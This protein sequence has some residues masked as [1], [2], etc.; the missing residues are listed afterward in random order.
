MKVL[1]Q[2]VSNAS[3]TVGERITWSIE[4]GYLLFLGV[5]DT[6]WPEQ[7]DYLVNKILNLRIFDSLDKKLDQ[8]IQQ[9]RGGILV[10]S[11]FTLY[12]SLKKGNR[13]DF[14]QSGEYQFSEK[15]YN[16]FVEKL[17]VKSDLN[18]ATG[19]FGAMMSVA[20]ENDGP[21]TLALER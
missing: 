5:T 17:R 20:L 10:V 18:I 7:I 15:I 12:A 3:V 9:V 19:E 6:D 1:L 11:Q 8:N 14:G 16:Q 2:R 13:P 21:F 4:H